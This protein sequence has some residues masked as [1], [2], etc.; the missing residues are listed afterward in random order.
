M[1]E[2]LLLLIK[3]KSSVSSESNEQ[4]FSFGFKRSLRAILNRPVRMS[5]H[6]LI[7]WAMDV[8]EETWI[9]IFAVVI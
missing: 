5:I 1:K 9:K 4:L 3:I 6:V 8:T 2:K 7:F